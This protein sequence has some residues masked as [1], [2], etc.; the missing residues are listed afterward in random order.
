MSRLFHWRMIAVVL[1]LLGGPA[2]Q[3]VLAQVRNMPRLRFVDQKQKTPARPSV[4]S[5]PKGGAMRGQPNL[6][7][8]AGLPPR[9][10]E[11]LR[12]MPPEEQ[13]R[14]LQNNRAFQNLVPE[15]QAQ[16]RK[17]LENWN[18]LTPAERDAI[19]QRAEIL[20]RMTPAQR[21]YLRNTL[22]PKWQAMPADRRQ[23]INGRLRILQSMGPGAQEAALA[24]PKF[25]QGLSPDEQSMLRDLNSFR[26]PPSEQ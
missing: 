5:Q 1:A 2:S 14:F 6:R 7:G 18:K 26:N 15:R 16:I 10:V 8:M 12:E 11:N 3:P 17:N 25:M 19:R 22:L 23:A 24:D 13:E 21:V 9:W 20:D 4:P